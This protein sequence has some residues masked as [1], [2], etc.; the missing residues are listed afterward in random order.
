[1]TDVRSKPHLF[2][3]A[4][5]LAVAF[6]M[7]EVIVLRAMG[8]PLV[9]PCG[10]IAW[11]YGNPAGAETS[12]HVTDWYSFTHVIHGF[13]FYFLL[14]LVAPRT[15]VVLRLALAVGLEATWEI[16][17]NTPLLIHRYRQAGLALGYTGDSIVNSISDTAATVLGFA[18]AR[19][20]PVWASVA[21]IVAIEA[22]LGYLIR[23]NFTLSVV[24]LLLPT[25][26]ITRWQN[27][28]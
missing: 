8:R 5:L 10:Y 20:V 9:C 6:L 23:D 22:S 1:M 25:E 14:W 11:W 2:A 7:A 17:E 24:Q 26:F 19:A 12:Q 16:V 27:G 4:C 18:L 15:P 13:G 3:T 28:N 21:L